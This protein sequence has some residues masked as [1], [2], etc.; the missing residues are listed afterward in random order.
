MIFIEQIFFGYCIFSTQIEFSYLHC[1][2]P[3]N[4]F[5]ILT[6]LHFLEKKMI[7]K[8]NFKVNLDDSM[9]CLY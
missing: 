1:Y 4:M 7:K 2:F 5:I 9:Q 3:I 6:V 8:S